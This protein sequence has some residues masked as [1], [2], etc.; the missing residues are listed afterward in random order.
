MMFCLFRWNSGNRKKQT[1][2]IFCTSKWQSYLSDL[3]KTDGRTRQERWTTTEP[4]RSLFVLCKRII[5]C[6]DVA[7]GRVVKGVNFRATRCG[8]PCG[9]CLAVM[10]KR[11]LT[12]LYSSTFVPPQTSQ[13]DV[14]CG[15]KNGRTKV[16]MPLCV[17]GGIRTI[18]DIRL[19]P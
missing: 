12:K 11:L 1:I 19:L 5:P 9:D 10:M 13:N 6:L 15:S 7:E 16:F 8:W 2:Q 4:L 3:M 17:G 18:E 14:R